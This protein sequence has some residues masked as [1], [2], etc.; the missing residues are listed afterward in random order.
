MY[1]HIYIYVYTHIY[2][3]LYIIIHS[4]TQIYTWIV[5]LHLPKVCAGSRKAQKRQKFWPRSPKRPK[6]RQWQ[7]EK[8]Q[9]KVQGIRGSGFAVFVQSFAGFCSFTGFE[10][11]EESL[12]GEMSGRHGGSRPERK[13]GAPLHS[14]QALNTKLLSRPSRRRTYTAV[15]SCE[16]SARFS[17]SLARPRRLWGWV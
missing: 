15:L 7:Q 9:K 4:H 12:R 17:R 14:A 2:A 6:S 16:I 8:L 3:C 10:G 1:I 5:A 11:A 13:S